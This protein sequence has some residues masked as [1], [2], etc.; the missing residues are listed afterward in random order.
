[1]P[2]QTLAALRGDVRADCYIKTSQPGDTTQK[3]QYVIS[4]VLIQF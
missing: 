1:M 3:C 2:K 4:A